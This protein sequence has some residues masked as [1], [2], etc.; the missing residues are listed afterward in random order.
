MPV[1]KTHQLRFVQLML[2]A[3]GVWTSQ[4]YTSLPS[5]TRWPK[6]LT[7]QSNRP[8]WERP[9]SLAPWVPLLRN[10]TQAWFPG[11]KKTQPMGSFKTGFTSK[12][13]APSSLHV[14]VELFKFSP[15]HCYQICR[16]GYWH[17]CWRM[18]VWVR[19]DIS[20]RR[21][22]LSSPSLP[23]LMSLM[24][25]QENEGSM[26]LITFSSPKHRLLTQIPKP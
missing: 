20:D 12:L 10:Y 14:T 26:L 13:P 11:G 1:G 8:R 5:C 24:F 21:E 15:S 18:H 16:V 19:W 22:P 17:L 7:S 4:S 9:G 6:Y 3:D 2:E 23:L 25:G